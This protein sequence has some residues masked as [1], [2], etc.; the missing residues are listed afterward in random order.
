MDPH[1]SRAASIKLF[2][3]L[4]G[5]VYRQCPNEGTRTLMAA[6]THPIGRVFTPPARKSLELLG[7]ART[8]PYP[9]TSRRHEPL[10]AA[11]EAARACA[12]LGRSRR[13]RRRRSGQ[14]GVSPPRRC[15]F[16]CAAHHARST[17][18]T[19][20]CSQTATGAPVTCCCP[21]KG[22]MAKACTKRVYT[23][24]PR[25]TEIH[26]QHTGASASCKPAIPENHV[27]CVA[28][29][30]FTCSSVSCG[31]TAAQCNEKGSTTAFC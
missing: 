11:A 10:C 13:R 2:L 15:A 9:R 30:K 16:T 31:A 19:E 12:R 27:C 3:R 24:R 1:L 22:A 8:S 14:R 21:Y 6:A 26:G 20:V 4:S 25:G 29:Q 7:G 28:A 17:A 23:E 18:Q 5:G